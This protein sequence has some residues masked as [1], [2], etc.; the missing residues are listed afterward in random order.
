MDKNSEVANYIGVNADLL[1]PLE[2]RSCL[3]GYVEARNPE[4]PY[5]HL[6]DMLNAQSTG[7][8]VCEC[9]SCMY[10]D[11]ADFRLDVFDACRCVGCNEHA[12][13]TPDFL[14]CV[15]IRAGARVVR[16][17]VTDALRLRSSCRD[18]DDMCAAVRWNH[19]PRV[20]QSV[21]LT[22]DH[23]SG[24][25]SISF[26]SIACVLMPGRSCHGCMRHSMYAQIFKSVVRITDVVGDIMCEKSLLTDHG[27]CTMLMKF[28]SGST[29]FGNLR[30]NR[31]I[32]YAGSRMALFNDSEDSLMEDNTLYNSTLSSSVD[33]INSVR[34]TWIRAERI[35]VGSQRTE[36]LDFFP[37]GND[38]HCGG[39]CFC[40]SGQ[41]AYTKRSPDW[42]RVRTRLHMFVSR[43]HGKAECRCMDS[44]D[45]ASAHDITDTCVSTKATLHRAH[46]STQKYELR[47]EKC[48]DE[49]QC[50]IVTVGQ[51]QGHCSNRRSNSDGWWWSASFS[52]GGHSSC[53]AY[54]MS[55]CNPDGSTAISPMSVFIACGAGEIG[56]DINERGKCGLVWGR[57]EY[58]LLVSYATPQQAFMWE[59]ASTVAVRHKTMSGTRISGNTRPAMSV[60]SLDWRLALGA[61]TAFSIFEGYTIPSFGLDCVSPDDIRFWE[62]YTGSCSDSVWSVLAGQQVDITSDFLLSGR[63]PPKLPCGVCCPLCRR[64]KRLLVGYMVGCSGGE[65]YHSATP[66]ESKKQQAVNP[67]VEKF[68]K[69]TTEAD[70]VGD[71]ME[72]SFRQLVHNTI[73]GCM[74]DED[75]FKS[76]KYVIEVCHGTGRKIPQ[77]YDTTEQ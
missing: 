43:L 77:W 5:E 13:A 24:S 66:C 74:G 39:C 2:E 3:T 35:F 18:I 65:H 59:L 40:E 72:R 21:E 57:R 41:S 61:F 70:S 68:L 12:H 46:M 14:V 54:F 25:K 58:D 29:E 48:P 16:L 62:V 63:E 23:V 30:F 73:K 33:D 20:K 51:L 19:M 44:A 10:R 42:E 45:Q 69:Y 67:L 56:Y 7:Q 50:K 32:I 36:R 37:E 27:E 8:E 34:D 26:K 9:D 22:L 47:I 6:K 71:N 15:T 64:M 60:G 11:V 17:Y 4:M 76:A 31:G 75:F 38:F 1:V 49:P 53:L 55:L 52:R 28:K